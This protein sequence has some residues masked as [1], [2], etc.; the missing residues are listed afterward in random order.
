[1]LCVAILTVIFSSTK[2]IGEKGDPK[3]I[4]RVIKIKMYDNYYEPNSITVKKGETIK[5]LIT[6]LG[7]MV[8]E[9]NIGTKEIQGGASIGFS[10]AS[11]TASY[12]AMK[13]LILD[14]VKDTFNPEF[15]NRLD[16]T[17]VYNALSKEDVLKIIDLQLID[18]QEN[19]DL[20]GLTLTV[21]RKAKNFLIDKGFDQEYGVRHLNREIQNLLE[22]P[23]SEL[24]LGKKF[25]DSKGVKV[26]FKNKKLSIVPLLGKASK[27]NADS[28]VGKKSRKSVDIKQ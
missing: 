1:M 23:L 12:D 16:E 27:K 8:H 28:K 4:D 22:D 18:L 26:D 21:T 5:F 11:N 20:L 9:Y 24:L 7:E 25:A 10:K 13:S 6:N 14:K 3:N 15:I 2:S 17:I 19:L